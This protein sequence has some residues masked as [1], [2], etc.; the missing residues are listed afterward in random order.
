VPP[1]SE[2]EQFE[3]PYFDFLQVPLQPLQDNLE[4]RTYEVFERDPVKY[5]QYEKVRWCSGWHLLPVC[6]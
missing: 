1:L 2:Q 6:A 5:V 3:A 4:S